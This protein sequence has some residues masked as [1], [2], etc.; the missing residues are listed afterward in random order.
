MRL[1]VKE[2][3]SRACFTCSAFCCAELITF[4]DSCVINSDKPLIFFPLP[5]VVSINH[6]LPICYV[7]IVVF[8]EISALSRHLHE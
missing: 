6:L 4:L 3:L 7:A 8:V 5:T 1:V 2:F